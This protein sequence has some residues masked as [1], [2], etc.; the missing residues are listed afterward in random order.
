MKESAAPCK[1]VLP[2]R[3]V[4]IKRKRQ[5]NINRRCTQTAKKRSA[6]SDVWIFKPRRK[7]WMKHNTKEG[8]RNAYILVVKPHL[9]DLNVDEKIV[10]IL[11]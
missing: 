10:I 4:T 9:G 3:I 6:K 7:K 11:K 2:K 8:M 5:E 1:A